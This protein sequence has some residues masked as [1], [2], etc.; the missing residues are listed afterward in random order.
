MSHPSKNGLII[1]GL[2]SH[3]ARN[4]KNL[5][6]KTEFEYS[7]RTEFGL[8]KMREKKKL[9]SVFQSELKIIDSQKLSS[10]TNLHF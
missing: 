4:L 8:C 9:Q 7:E 5:M 3:M 1:S 10:K 6:L 2:D